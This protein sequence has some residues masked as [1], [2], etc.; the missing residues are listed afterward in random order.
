[1]I[2]A[3]TITAGFVLPMLIALLAS[4]VSIAAFRRHMT[5]K[6]LLLSA[7][8]VGTGVVAGMQIVESLTAGGYSA[9]PLLLIA[10]ALLFA[11][12]QFGLAMVFGAVTRLRQLAS[13]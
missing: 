10:T 8:V 4:L 2:A 1:M 3:V 7:V 5:V 13:A 6:Q 11:V 12:V 9:T